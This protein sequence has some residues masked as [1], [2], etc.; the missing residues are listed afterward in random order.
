[1]ATKTT[2]TAGK[3]CL[4]FLTMCQAFNSYGLCWPWG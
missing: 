4:E 3:A 2:T 1:V